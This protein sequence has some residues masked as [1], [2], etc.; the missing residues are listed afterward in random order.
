MRID[1]M[2]DARCACAKWPNRNRTISAIVYDV[3][4][5]VC[6]CVC[7][8]F[9]SL[10]VFRFSFNVYRIYLYIIYIFLLIFASTWSVPVRMCLYN[11]RVYVLNTR[12]LFFLFVVLFFCYLFIL[13]VDPKHLFVKNCP[14]TATFASSNVS[15]HCLTTQLN[16]LPFTILARIG[17][18]SREKMSNKYTRTTR[19]RMI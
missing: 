19:I 15:F 5:C 16:W 10:T 9:T 4:S 1:I 14:S 2:C 18:I 13:R 7:I 17:K 3:W 8:R 11:V 12:A 6:V